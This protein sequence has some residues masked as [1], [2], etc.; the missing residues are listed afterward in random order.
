[1]I[2]TVVLTAVL[3][4]VGAGMFY[5]ATRE[6]R[7][8]QADYVGGQAFYYAEGGIEN[9]LDILNYAATESQLTKVRQDQSSDGYG[10]LMDPDVADRMLPACTDESQTGCQENIQ[11]KIGNQ[12]YTVYVD[13]V[14][15]NNGSWVHC[16]ASDNCGLDLSQPNAKT[17]LRITAEGQSSEGY[18]KLQQVVEVKSSNFP[19]SLYV[20]GDAVINGE[21]AITDQDI[22][23]RGSLGGRGK[24]HLDGGGVFATGQIYHGKLDT[25]TQIY[26]PTSG[27]QTSYWSAVD[28]DPIF[29]RDQNGPNGD[30]FTSYDL[31]D[32]FNTSGLSSTQLAALK[33]QAKLDNCETPP[34]NEGC[35]LSTGSKNVT[36]QQSDLPNLDGNLVI[37]IE[38]SSGDACTNNADLKF[39]WPPQGT[40][41][42]AMIVVKNG[43]VTM[44]GGSIGGLQ[45]IVYCPDGPVTVHGSGNQKFTGFIWGQACPGQ[46][47]NGN[48]GNPGLTDIGNF[49]FS[50]NAA[51]YEDLPFFAWTVTRLTDW[52]EV[53]R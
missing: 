24:L 17:N 38:F 22:Y 7:M 28:P 31:E 30:T 39:D 51:F 26:S 3:M 40:S 20:N 18:R 11:M 36:I 35:Y 41:G 16:A 23:I 29:D 21:T 42:K 4:V 25:N 13:E 37:Y 19:L 1:M 49:D 53:D 50:M 46:E 15:A 44:E 33:S 5:M 2:T 43:T 48:Q 27:E 6:E 9:V 32:E 45:G 34:F 12:N 14:K 52:T 10:K 8:S 47:N